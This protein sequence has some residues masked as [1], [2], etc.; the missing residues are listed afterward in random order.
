MK[1]AFFTEGGYTG[2]IPR[3]IP[4]RTDQAW[5]CVLNA[6]HH[7]VFKLNEVN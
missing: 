5:I 2:K 4:M 7:C 6:V 3:N 1:I